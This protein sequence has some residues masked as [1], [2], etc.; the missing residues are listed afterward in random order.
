MFRRAARASL[1]LG[2]LAGLFLVMAGP[3][4]TAQWPPGLGPSA[5]GGWLLA[6]EAGQLPAAGAATAPAGPTALAPGQPA[7][8][9]VGVDIRAND[10]T[11]DTP[12][13]GLPRARRRWRR[14]AAR[15]ARA[16][17]TPGREASPGSRARRTSDRPGRTSGGSGPTAIRWSSRTT[18]RGAS[19]TPSSAARRPA[20]CGRPTT[21]R[22]SATGSTSARRRGHDAERQAVRRRRQLRRREQRQ[23]LRLLD[24]VLRHDQPRRHRRHERA[25][26]LALDR[27][28]CDLRQRADPPGARPGT[29]RLQ[30]QGRA[31]R[32]GVRCLGRPSRRDPGDIRF[33]ALDGRRVRPSAPTVQVSTGTASR[34]IDRVV[35]CGPNNNRTT[36]NGEHP[37]CSIRRGSPWTRRGQPS[38][39]ET[40]TPCGSTDPTGAPRQQ[41]TFSSAVR[42]TAAR[43]GARPSSWAAGAPRRTSSSR[44]SRSEETRAL[45]SVAW[46]DRRNDAAN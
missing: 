39:T 7:L 23:R 17:T 41:R 16:T 32:P 21:A 30:Y 2:L 3:A 36:L 40:C 31:E 6:V 11:D 45:V 13:R 28:R 46:Y 26:L 9:P 35:D 29:L 34:A 14:T 10:P 15:S 43:R 4:R 37:S 33:R 19:T 20:S 8:A 18:P 22:R 44:S 1:V 38:A 27:R 42:R 12:E 24:A 5:A 25:A